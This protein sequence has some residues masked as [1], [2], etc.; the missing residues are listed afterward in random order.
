MEAVLVRQKVFIVIGISEHL[1][2]L[3]H[4]DSLSL[5]IEWQKEWHLPTE[6]S[7]FDQANQRITEGAEA[8]DDRR[9]ELAA[10]ALREQV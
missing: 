3:L 10:H 8:L 2:V 5:G 4:Y 6:I 9:D 7:S 1:P